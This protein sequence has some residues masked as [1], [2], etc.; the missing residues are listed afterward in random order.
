DRAGAHCPTKHVIS[1]AS[2]GGGSA[3]M[4]NQSGVLVYLRLGVEVIVD[5]RQIAGLGDVNAPEVAHSAAQ[6]WFL[7]NAD[8]DLVVVDDRCRDDVVGRALRLALR[9][10]GIAI[11]LPDRLSRLRL[12]CAQPAVA[13]AKND[14]WLPIHDGISGVGPLAENDLVAGRIVLP[15]DLA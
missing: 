6:R 5:G 4:P 13:A 10:F 11:E 14:L 1:V 7:A 15:D 12:E 2:L 8:I 9:S 3:V